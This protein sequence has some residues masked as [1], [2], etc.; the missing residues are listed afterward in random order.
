MTVRSSPGPS[1]AEP[2]PRLTLEGLVSRRD[3]ELRRDQIP[4][5]IRS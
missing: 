1:N 3:M 5:V 4:E 2:L